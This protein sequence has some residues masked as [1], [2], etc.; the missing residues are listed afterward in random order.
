[1][2]KNN[3]SVLVIG[4][5]RFGSAIAEEL[6]DAGIDVA[7]LDNDPELIDAIKHRTSVAFVGDA[8]D[9]NVLQG[10]SLETMDTVIISF[11]RF[12]EASVLCVSTLTEAKVPYIVARAE[13]PRQRQVLQAVGAHR[14][15]ELERDMGRRFANELPALCR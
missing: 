10:V 6:W 9:P 5:G 1:M 11:G 13:T 15:L 12:F 3:H 14:V 8:T 7:V 4:L 2:G